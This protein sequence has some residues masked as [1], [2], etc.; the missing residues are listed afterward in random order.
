MWQRNTKFFFWPYSSPYNIQHKEFGDTSPY[1][2]HLTLKLLLLLSFWVKNKS[3]KSW[4]VSY[5]ALKKN[6]HGYVK[7][8]SLH[9]GWIHSNICKPYTYNTTQSCYNLH[10]KL[11][12]PVNGG[13]KM[14]VYFCYFKS[15]LCK[16]LL[17][18]GL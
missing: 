9:F 11:D 13:A 18:A 3:F 17:F 1:F 10:I 15:G 14:W 4:L 2:S 8:L 5:L 16:R 12:Y 7:S 6:N